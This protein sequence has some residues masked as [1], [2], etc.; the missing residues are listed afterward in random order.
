MRLSWLLY[1]AMALTALYVAITVVLP[2]L[3]WVSPRCTF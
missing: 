3:C 1:G 2:L